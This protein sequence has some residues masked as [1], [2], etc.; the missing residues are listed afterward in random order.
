MKEYGFTAQELHWFDVRK[1]L[2]APGDQVFVSFDQGRTFE[3]SIYLG[4]IS[5]TV[6]DD[7]RSQFISDGPL[8]P[9][10][11]RNLPMPTHWSYRESTGE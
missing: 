9:T 11:G 10:K 2:P 1:A 8:I 6:V 4:P 3:P 5:H 7:G